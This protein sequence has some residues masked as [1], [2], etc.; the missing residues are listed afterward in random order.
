MTSNPT[1]ILAALSIC[2]VGSC[3]QLKQRGET[4]PDAEKP[5]VQ[6]Y[7]HCSSPYEFHNR[8]TKYLY[9]MSNKELS[10]LQE[11]P[12]LDLSLR[13]AWEKVRRTGTYRH[14]RRTLDTTTITYFL[15][16]VHGR[17]GVLS[18]ATWR[19]RL[20]TA[21]VWQEEYRNA[22][23]DDEPMESFKHEKATGNTSTLGGTIS[24]KDDN[25]R[26]TVDGEFYTVSPT[27]LPNL[28]VTS[29]IMATY[30]GNN[31]LFVALHGYDCYPYTLLCFDKQKGE[32][33][34]HNRVWA[35]GGLIDYQGG[36]YYHWVQI[37]SNNGSIVVF[38]IGMDA[39][40][41]EAFEEDTGQADFRFS[42]SY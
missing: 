32:L 24:R 15:E 1:T 12:V 33:I 37:V 16:F 13:A 41:I 29:T 20:S 28:H 5:F 11:D 7:S 3:T 38:G 10:V 40:Y 42:T 26:I 27:I 30:H 14:G 18:P 36:G 2:A 22:T 8:H 21:Q 35:G 23:F 6:G 4:S 34:W 19:S 17:I 9:A 31:R 25:L 39:A